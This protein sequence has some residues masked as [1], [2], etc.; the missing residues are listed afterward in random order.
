MAQR[1]K[2]GAGIREQQIR[3]TWLEQGRT[4]VNGHKRRTPGTVLTQPAVAFPLPWI[5]A[6]LGGQ[7]VA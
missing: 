6:L 5:A 7:P 3:A 4:V 1:S 2:T